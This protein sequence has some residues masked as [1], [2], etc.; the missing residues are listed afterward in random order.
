MA[1]G[2]TN[3]VCRKR[4]RMSPAYAFFWGETQLF[5][6]KGEIHAIS[7]RGLDSTAGSRIAEQLLGPS[8]FALRERP[9]PPYNIMIAPPVGLA[10]IN[11]TATR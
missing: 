10:T 1:R 4:D 7:L 6:E 8:E 3:L 5:D 9:I 11:Q 2:A